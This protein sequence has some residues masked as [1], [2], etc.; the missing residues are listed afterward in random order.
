[1][2]LAANQDFTVRPE[3]VVEAVFPG[4]QPGTFVR[5]RLLL[6]ERS[7]ARELWRR[8]GQYLDERP[9]R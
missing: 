2:R 9:G 8:R 4:A 7:Q 3:Q 6:E 1:M 5:E